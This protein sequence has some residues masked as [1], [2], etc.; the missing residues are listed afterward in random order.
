MLIH[1]VNLADLD[2]RLAS[3]RPRPRLWGS[4]T[5]TKTKTLMSKT[6]TK[7]KTKT[8]MSKTKTETQDLHHQYLK[9]MTAM[10]C[11]IQKD[12]KVM[13]SRKFSALVVAHSKQ[14]NIIPCLT[15]VLFLQLPLIIAVYQTFSH[16]CNISQVWCSINMSKL[17]SKCFWSYN[18]RLISHKLC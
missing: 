10:D 4:K 6:K 17:M 7:T 13:A 1:Q 2:S 3:P 16:T 5:K 8:L 11:D 12:W 9:S 14:Q 18:Y 15:T